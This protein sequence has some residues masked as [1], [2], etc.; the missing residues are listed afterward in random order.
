[1]WTYT[2]NDKKIAIPYSNI[3]HVILSKGLQAAWKGCFHHKEIDNYCNSEYITVI[4]KKNGGFIYVEG[5]VAFN[6][7]IITPGHR[8]ACDKD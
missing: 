7:L 5:E 6:Q 4:Y 3:D 8:F 1:M 2:T